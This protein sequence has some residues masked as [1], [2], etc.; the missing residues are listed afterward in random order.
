MKRIILIAAAVIFPMM[1]MAQN[2]TSNDSIFIKLDDVDI[3][4]GPSAF[5]KCFSNCDI[6]GDGLVSYAEAAK[7]TRLILD[8]GG[9]KNIISDYSF[10]KYFPNLTELSIG[11]TPN[12]SIDLSNNPKLEKINLSNGLWI[13]EVTIAMGC[14]PQI[15]FPINDNDVTFKRVR[16]EKF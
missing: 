15:F 9:R 1:A 4:G 5:A 13:K 7:A 3:Y 14:T 12:E 8:Y 10:L 6:N 16:T 2:K 11:N